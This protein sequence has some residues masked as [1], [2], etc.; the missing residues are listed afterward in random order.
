MD[1]LGLFQPY[2]FLNHTLQIVLPCA[3]ITDPGYPWD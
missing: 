2:D 1:K 3:R